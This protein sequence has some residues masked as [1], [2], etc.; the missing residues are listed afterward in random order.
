MS[1]PHMHEFFDA[2]QDL[3]TAGEPRPQRQ[4]CRKCD[5]SGQ[6][7]DGHDCNL[8]DGL[9]ATGNPRGSMAEFERKMAAHRR[10]QEG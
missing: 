7:G 9:V 1:K 8:C 5:G 3:L 2:M 6:T 4:P 10:K